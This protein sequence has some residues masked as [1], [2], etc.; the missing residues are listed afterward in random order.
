[1]KEWNIKN[2]V[3]VTIIHLHINQIPA[4]NNSYGVDTPLI[5][6]IKSKAK[7]DK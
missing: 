1:M 4:L 2:I 5:N 7:R 3:K 6:Q